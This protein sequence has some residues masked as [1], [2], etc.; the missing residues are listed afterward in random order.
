MQKTSEKNRPQKCPLGYG[1]PENCNFGDKCRF[2]HSVDE[3]FVIEH[4]HDLR[5]YRNDRR[6]DRIWSHDCK[7][8]IAPYLSV[9]WLDT[10]NCFVVNETCTHVFIN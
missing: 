4:V 9:C 3:A 5:E 2:I 1:S 6:A 10:H 7:H 8:C